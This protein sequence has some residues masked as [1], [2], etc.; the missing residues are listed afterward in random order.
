MAV[1]LGSKRMQECCSVKELLSTASAAAICTGAR[2][3]GIPAHA[4]VVQSLGADKQ[5]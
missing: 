4:E 5:C 1:E 2:S 3:V